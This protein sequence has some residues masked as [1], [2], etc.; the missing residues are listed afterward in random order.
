MRDLLIVAL[1]VPPPDLPVEITW[2]EGRPFG[3]CTEGAG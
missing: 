1:I 3:R 2:P